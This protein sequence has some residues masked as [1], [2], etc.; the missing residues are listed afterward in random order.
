MQVSCV[1]TPIKVLNLSQIVLLCSTISV[2]FFIFY[3]TTRQAQNWAPS[4]ILSRGLCLFFLQNPK[5][6]NLTE[7][8]KKMDKLRHT[9]CFVNIFRICFDGRIFPMFFFIPASLTFNNIYERYCTFQC[10]PRLATHSARTT[11]ALATTRTT[12][13]SSPLPTTPRPSS[14]R[15]APFTSTRNSR[16]RQSLWKCWMR[17]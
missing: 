5:H 8:I 16:H 3:S 7:Q 11:S 9:D 12:P 4:Q 13:C 10:P 15:S 14:S 1:K 6:R 2:H 17:Q